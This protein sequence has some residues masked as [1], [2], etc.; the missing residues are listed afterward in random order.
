[1]PRAFLTGWF[2]RHGFATTDAGETIFVPVSALAEIADI[3]VGDL[4][5]FKAVVDPGFPRRKAMGIRL[6]QRRYPPGKRINYGVGE[7]AVERLS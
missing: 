3:G 2:G 7:A 4:I 5:E 6:I 1:M